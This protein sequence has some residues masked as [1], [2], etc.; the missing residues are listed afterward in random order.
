MATPST[1]APP[2]AEAFPLEKLSNDVLQRIAVFAAQSILKVSPHWESYPDLRWPDIEAVQ[3]YKKWLRNQVKF[4]DLH[5]LS[6]VNK[7]LRALCMPLMFR[8]LVVRFHVPKHEI[9]NSLTIHGNRRKK[10]T[11]LSRTREYYD[12]DCVRVFTRLLQS[13]EIV[14]NLRYVT[15]NIVFK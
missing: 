5:A 12:N 10:I 3:K 1:Q 9:D 2:L 7:R 14:A 11:Y 15:S 8:T 13:Q 4:H 6:L